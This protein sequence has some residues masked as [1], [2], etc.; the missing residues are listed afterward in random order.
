MKKALF[1]LLS[2]IFCI[3]VL[4]SAENPYVKEEVLTVVDVMT[5]EPNFSHFITLLNVAHLTHFLEDEGP[6]TIFA[7]TNSAFDALPKGTW[8]EFLKPQNFTTLQKFLKEHIIAKKVM[9]PN[10]K[11]FE[12]QTISGKQLEAQVNDGIVTINGAQIV[13]PNRQGANG[14]VHG[15]SSLMPQK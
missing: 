8:S 3:P 11:A 14:V 13:I 1:N 9:S 6:F 7:P 15:I 4:C 10:L 2:F 12:L 5:L